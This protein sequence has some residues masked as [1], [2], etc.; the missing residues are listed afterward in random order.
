MGIVGY[1]YRNGSSLTG[2]QRRWAS[3][4]GGGAGTRGRVDAARCGVQKKTEPREPP[5]LGGSRGSGRGPRGDQNVTSDLG[6]IPD[7]FL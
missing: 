2:R 7:I 3:G 6:K 4:P 1:P 5:S